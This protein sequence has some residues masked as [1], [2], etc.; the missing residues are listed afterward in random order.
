MSGRRA[1]ILG[2]FGLSASAM[3][4]RRLSPTKVP[5]PKD[6]SIPGSPPG[7]PTH[8]NLRRDTLACPNDHPHDLP[9]LSFSTGTPASPPEGSITLITKPDRRGPPSLPEHFYRQTGIPFPACPR[10][11]CDAQSSIHDPRFSIHR[12]RFAIRT[13]IPYLQY[14]MLGEFQCAG[15]NQGRDGGKLWNPGVAQRSGGEFQCAGAPCGDSGIVD[16]AW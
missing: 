4:R 10:F 15:Q 16:R 1:V 9:A 13:T 12:P 11:A 7:L 3:V 5:F 8:R 6:Q 2:C 14:T